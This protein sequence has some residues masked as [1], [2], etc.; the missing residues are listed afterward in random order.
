MQPGTFVVT[1]F[2]IDAKRTLDYLVGLTS[3]C[4]ANGRRKAHKRALLV[5]EG[6]RRRSGIGSSVPIKPKNGK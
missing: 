2:M 4:A 5:T 1:H 6:S 3:M